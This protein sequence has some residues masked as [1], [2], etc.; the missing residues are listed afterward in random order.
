MISK[1]RMLLAALLTG[2]LSCDNRR[3]VTQPLP[4]QPGT[5]TVRLTTPRADDGAIVFE[6]R[7]QGDATPQLADTTMWMFTERVDSTLTRVVLVGDLV[8]GPLV[9]FEVVD[10]QRPYTATL[11]QVSD[12]ANAVRAQ[13]QDYDLAIA[14]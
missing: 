3:D 2:A 4:P 8:S 13:L 12:R 6:L 5:L 11:V 7:G 10:V 1:K 9:T 14:R